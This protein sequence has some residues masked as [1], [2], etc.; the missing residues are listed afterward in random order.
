MG[1]EAVG[2]VDFATLETELLNRTASPLVTRPAPL[3]SI[4]PVALKWE[5]RG[6]Y[7]PRSADSLWLFDSGGL[8]VHSSWEGAQAAIRRTIG[9]CDDEVRT[10]AEDV[11]VGIPPSLPRVVAIARVRTILDSRLGIAPRGN[12]DRQHERLVDLAAA[13]S[14]EAPVVDSYAEAH[15]WVEYFLL[16]QRFQWLGELRL[17]KGDVVS[18]H[19]SSDLYDEVSSIGDDGK[20]YF[21]G[22]RGA[23]AWP[24]QLTVVA[25]HNDKSESSI[26]A[27]RLAKNRA[28][29]RSITP[30]VSR[31]KL[32]ALEPYAVTEEAS[33]EDIEEL[34]RILDE[35]DNEKPIQELLE[36]RPQ[37]LTSLVRGPSRYCRPQV[38]LGGRY[39]ADFLLADI[40]SNGIRWILVELETPHSCVAQARR[41]DFD[42]SA[43][44]GVRQINEWRQWIEDNP[45]TAHRSRQENGIGL[46][47]IR[48]QAEGIVLVGR[49]EKLRPAAKILRRRLHE[50]ERIRMQTYDRLVEQ[51]EGARHF[52][53][54]WSSNPNRL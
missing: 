18:R 1:N 45:D 13:V 16:A 24:D 6:G 2:C 27:R 53:G 3:S 8:L 4:Q 36:R 54:P 39:V 30:T 34:R 43:R 52:R 29:E 32:A 28:A 25:R 46:P 44:T 11:G 50:A 9:D 14:V 23:Q 12:T 26:R 37:L 48:P 40:D 41:N 35:A 38:R 47:D 20:V 51:L 21:T 17:A 15:A 49:R 10:I 31:E 22:G 7:R 5:A 42:L 19:L 33:D